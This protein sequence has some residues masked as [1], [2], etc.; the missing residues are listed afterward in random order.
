MRTFLSKRGRIGFLVCIFLCTISGFANAQECRIHYPDT[1]IPG[2]EPIVF[3]PGLVSSGEHEF[4]CCFSPDGNAFYFT[5]ALG[6]NK[7]KSVLV[8][9]YDGEKWSQP[10]E[11][12]PDFE[13]ETY[14]PHITE[15]GM[16]LYFMGMRLD[17]LNGE[18]TMLMDL[19]YAESTNKG[20][21]KITHLGAPFNPLNSMFVSTCGD[22]IYTTNRSG[23]GPDIVYVR[24]ED[25]HFSSFTDPGETINTSAPELYPFIARDGSYLLFNR[26]LDGEKL[27]FVCFK[28]AN[29]QWGAAVE[30]PLG[31]ESGC[32]MVSPDGRFLFF[33][34]GKK[35]SNDIYWVSSE[36]FLG[37]K[38]L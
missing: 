6:Q 2:K 23:E 24:K 30:V 16:K 31:I 5:R 27:L 15:D 1:L 36:V 38:P 35:F 14:E 37:L 13:G 29:G 7:K 4:S 8:I 20:W 17:D 10:E 26:V 34:A 32:P 9:K 11:A 22:V 25:E 28:Q 19:Y 33:N 3:A 18:K 12:L 21:T